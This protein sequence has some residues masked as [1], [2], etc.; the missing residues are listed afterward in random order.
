M[1]AL[2]LPACPIKHYRNPQSYNLKVV[3][4]KL[5]SLISEFAHSNHTDKTQHSIAPQ[6]RGSTQAFLT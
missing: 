6:F 2:K 1:T 3:G 5:L 4:Q